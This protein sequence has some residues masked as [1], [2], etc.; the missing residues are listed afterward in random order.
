MM[1]LLETMLFVAWRA[2]D[3]LM[4]EEVLREISIGVYILFLCFKNIYSGQATLWKFSLEI[5]V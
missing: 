5:F 2:V 4:P 3:V 1:K